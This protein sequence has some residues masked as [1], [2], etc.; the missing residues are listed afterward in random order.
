MIRLHTMNGGK[1]LRSSRV[2][3]RPPPWVLADGKVLA[4]CG[5]DTTV[6]VYDLTKAEARQLPP[7]RRQPGDPGRRSAAWR[8]A[9]ASGA[10]AV[11]SPDG[12]LLATA[13][14]APHGLGGAGG[15]RSPAAKRHQP[16]RRS[17]GKAIRKIDSV[18]VSPRLLAGRPRAGD[19]ERGRVGQSV[20]V[21]SGRSGA[22]LGQVAA[23]AAPEPAGPVPPVP[24]AVAPA[25][26]GDAGTPTT[27]PLA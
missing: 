22:W 23:P 14:L 18:P 20:E 26:P 16:D 1:E 15:G 27:P 13:G 12:K 25:R 6:R 4:G 24:G 19:G 3:P 21:A 17:T 8:A 10:G 7:S 2:T 5:A 11:F 9:S